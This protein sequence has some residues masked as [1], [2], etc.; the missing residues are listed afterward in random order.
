M[1][2]AAKP[3]P[4]ADYDLVDTRGFWERYSPNGE[5][6]WSSAVSLVLFA[7]L[8]LL[9]VVLIVPFSQRD[10]TP[11]AVDVLYV[12]EDQNA[13]S[14][15]D[16]GFDTDA[17]LDASREQLFEEP[18]VQAAIDELDE[19][20]ETELPPPEVKPVDQGK[21]L[22][23]ETQVAQATLNQLAQAIEQLN[24]NIKQGQGGGSGG[25]EG[26]GAGG[27]GARVARW[28]LKFNS[29]TSKHY[30]EQLDGLGAEVAFPMVGNKWQ[31]YL[32]VSS[33]SRMS[34]VRDLTSESRLYWVDEKPE[35][36]SGVAQELGIAV[37]PFMIVFLPLPLEDRMLEMELAYQNLREDEIQRTD[38]E[39]ISRGGGYDVKITRQIPR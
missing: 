11:P 31:Y 18:P 9:P 21:E 33:T 25:L 5:L 22:E 12:G 17:A 24:A 23:R 8:V 39:V 6:P 7:F 10:P 28:V 4:P 1:P 34:E 38:F 20:P 13:P 32:N 27:R 15:E 35:S 19:V 2:A 36:I 3:P 30:L 14:G 16:E 37:P 26:G 29:R